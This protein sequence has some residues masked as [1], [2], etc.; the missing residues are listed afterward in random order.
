MFKIT[1]LSPQKND[2]QRLNV[3]LDGNFGFG[4]ARKVAPWLQVGQEISQEKINELREQD[5]IEKGYQRALHYLSY[6]ERSEKEVQGNLRKHDIP[7][8]VIEDILE[9]LHRNTLLNDKRFAEKW[10][11]NRTAFHPQIG[12]AHV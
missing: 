7:D 9:R 4:V 2:P 5:A 3:Y 1:D 6:R 11:E 8:Q 12:R 10:V